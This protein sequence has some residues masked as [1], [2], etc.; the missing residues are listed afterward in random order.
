MCLWGCPEGAKGSADI[1]IWPDAIQHGARLVTGARVRAI[2]SNRAGLATGAD[3]VDRE[4]REHHQAA[5]VVVLAA[6]GIGTPRLLLLSQSAGFPHGLANSS[7]LVGKRLML[8]PVTSALGVYEEGLDSWLGPFGNAIY[9]LEFAEGDSSRGFPRG[10]HWECCPIPGPVEVL[11]RY[12]QLPIR[13]R[14]GEE[15]HQ[16]VAGGLGHMFE[17][18]ITVEDLPDEANTVT[19]DDVLTDSDG[20]P[21]PRITY[22]LSGTTKS[23]LSWMANRGVEAHLA[24]GATSTFVTGGG[25]PDTGW[26]LLGT[27]RMGTDPSSSVVN[28]ACQAHDVPNLYIVDGSAFV[29]AS[30]VNPTA[31]IG[32]V[33]LRCASLMI[34]GS[35]SQRV[36]T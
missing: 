20:I 29:T 31:T 35:R 34:S 3:W 17:W 9:T 26:H 23:A 2:T 32:A 13:A 4:G 12:A 11:A 27:A 15:L 28:P 7:G 33:A 1:T 36:P 14:T 24:S 18:L 6:N 22:R 21:A 25:M 16:L 8:H 30:S 19:L 10:S 5:D